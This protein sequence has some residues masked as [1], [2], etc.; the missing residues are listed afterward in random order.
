M[1]FVILKRDSFKIFPGCSNF[2]SVGKQGER[3]REGLEVQGDAKS[4]ELRPMHASAQRKIAK[5]SKAK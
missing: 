4:A 1:K 5:D 2:L 3:K